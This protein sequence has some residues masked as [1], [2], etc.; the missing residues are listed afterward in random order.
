MTP[1][2]THK[3]TGGHF[4]AG[5]IS[6]VKMPKAAGYQG[7]PVGTKA[8]SP[9]Q[10]TRGVLPVETDSVWSH[11]CICDETLLLRGPP[12]PITSLRIPQPSGD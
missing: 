12:A 6:L 10:A 11:P 4:R 3:M 1:T 9:G 8:V 5:T 7:G 2:P